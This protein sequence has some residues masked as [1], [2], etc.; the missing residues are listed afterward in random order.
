MLK[1]EIFFTPSL[2]PLSIREAH[3][4]WVRGTLPPALTAAS[5]LTKFCANMHRD[6]L[7]KTFKFQGHVYKIKVTMSFCVFL[8]VWSNS[9]GFTK[10]HSVDGATLLLSAEMTAVTRGQYLALNKAWRSC[11]IYHHNHAATSSSQV[12]SVVAWEQALR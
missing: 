4:R 12:Y 7:E 9:P 10:C 1:L 6:S 11:W 2:R 8:G 3:S 5:G